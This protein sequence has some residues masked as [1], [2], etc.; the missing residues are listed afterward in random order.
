MPEHGHFSDVVWSDVELY[1]K[2]EGLAYDGVG[3]ENPFIPHAKVC[4]N[5]CGL[6]DLH[7]SHTALA[8]LDLTNRCNMKCP[9]CFANA[10]QS[11]Y[12]YEPSFDEVVKMMQVL[13]ATSLFLARPSSS[14]VASRPSILSSLTWSRRPRSWASLRSRLPPTG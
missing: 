7:L 3:V 5:D 10:N 12:V 13:R 8:N 9:I 14:P 11:G 2:S 4:P 1:L 6:C